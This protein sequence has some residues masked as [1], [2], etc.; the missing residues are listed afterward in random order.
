MTISFSTLDTTEAAAADTL[1]RWLQVLLQCPLV[2]N[3]GPKA[4][5]LDTSACRTRR[6]SVSTSSRIPLSKSR[7]QSCVR[8]E[9]HRSSG[10][11]GSV[12]IANS[13]VCRANY[14]RAAC[15]Y[16]FRGDSVGSA[17]MSKEAAA[18]FRPHHSA[19]GLHRSRPRQGH[20]GAA[21]G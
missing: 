4:L 8:G 20:V 6:T 3:S 21:H 12:G 10:S 15:Q 5:F 19:A 2:Y 16:D 14:R 1:A 7:S 9:T 17:T 11:P 13:S 18:G